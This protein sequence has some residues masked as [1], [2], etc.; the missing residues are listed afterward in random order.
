MSGTGLIY[1]FI[2]RHGQTLK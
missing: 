1:F 2:L